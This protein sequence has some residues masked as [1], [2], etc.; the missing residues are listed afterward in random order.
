MSDLVMVLRAVE[1]EML[2]WEGSD[3]WPAACKEAADRIEALEA[4]VSA[5]RS[6]GNKDCTAMADD[7]LI[8]NSTEDKP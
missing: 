7:W 2:D 6:W 5:L 1:S 3:A 8:N 4:E